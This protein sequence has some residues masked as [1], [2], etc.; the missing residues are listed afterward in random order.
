MRA[1]SWRA[2][3]IEV[4]ETDLGESASSSST[5]RSRAIWSCRRSTSCAAT[6][7]N[8]FAA[9][10]R[11]RS[12]QRATSITWPNSQR[13]EYAAADSCADDAGMTGVQF[14][15]RRNGHRRGLH[16]RRQRRPLGQH[17][18]AAYRA[19]SGIEKL[20]PRSRPSRACSSACLSR[21]A[22][23]SPMT[24]YTSHFRAPRDGGEM[25]VV[26]VDNGRSER[27]GDGG[28]LALAQ[29]HSLRGVHEHV[30]G[31]PAQRRVEL[32]RAPS[33]ARSA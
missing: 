4:M 22:L 5:T 8:V 21:S 25:H 28:V 32:W 33:W 24:Q 15:G 26:L 29:M 14:R 9:N 18:A 10:D 6:S 16:E 19:R 1:V 2:R 3:G 20:I 27:L 17:A 11:H 30:P 23:G 31:V 7:P 12:G 13:D